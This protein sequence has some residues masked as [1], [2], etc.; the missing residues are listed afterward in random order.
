M[1]ASICPL[2]PSAGQRK[3][4]RDQV[5][6]PK[7][8]LF[9]RRIV[10][11]LT[12]GHPLRHNGLACC[13]SR[14]GICTRTLGI[15]TANDRQSDTQISSDQRTRMEF[16]RGTPG[17]LDCAGRRIAPSILACCVIVGISLNG[18]FGATGPAVMM[19]RPDSRAIIC[20]C[21]AISSLATQIDAWPLR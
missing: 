2:S 14:R 8:C 11:R 9:P 15:Q 13:L 17:H 10:P 19:E 3:H 5:T 4:H 1:E 18:Q 12:Y 7:N 6:A 21:V 16:L 20:F